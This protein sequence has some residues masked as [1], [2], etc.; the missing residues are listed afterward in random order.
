MK[1][2][3]VKTETPAPSE[4]LASITHVRLER[5]VTTVIPAL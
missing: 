2:L 5:T 1:G 3:L 4:I